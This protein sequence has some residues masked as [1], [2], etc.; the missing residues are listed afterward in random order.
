MESFLVS[1]DCGD[2]IFCDSIEEAR[3]VIADHGFDC[4]WT[5]DGLTFIDSSENSNPQGEG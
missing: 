5:L 3:Q 2:T 1:F 4:G